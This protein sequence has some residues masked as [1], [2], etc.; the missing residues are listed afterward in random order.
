MI[1]K[2]ARYG[3]VPDLLYHR[4][5][6]YVAPVEQAA[7]PP[8]AGEP[9]I[10]RHAVVGAGYDDAKQWFIVRNSRGAQWDKKGYFTLPYA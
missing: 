9:A 7:A 8:N 6:S 3:W 5:R 4:D 1:F 2:T 10:G